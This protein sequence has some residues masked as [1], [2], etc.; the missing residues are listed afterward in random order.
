MLLAESSLGTKTAVVQSPETRYA[1]SGE[2][3][4]AYQVVG[5]APLD[6][7]YIPNG[8]HHV[9]LNWEN[10]PVARFLERLA[11]LT[12]L[13]VFDKRGTGMSDRVVGVPTLET[14]MDDVRA[15]MDAASSDRAVLFA[16][17]DAGPL[18]ALFAATFPERSAGLVL[19]NSTPRFV[20]GPDFPWLPSR[21]EAEGRVEENLRRAVD[22]ARRSELF[23]QGNPDA[24]E[25]EIR[26]FTRVFRISVSPGARAEAQRWNLDVDVS[27]IL[28][29]IRVPTL[30]L[31]RPEIP[32]PDVGSGRYFA[33]HIPGARLVELPGRNFGPP[34]G[35]TG[36]LFTEL[37]RFLD[38]AQSRRERHES[39]PERVLTTVLF[40][41]IV[42][43]TVRASELGDRA[44]GEL[45]G[46]HHSLIRGQLGHFRGQEMDT[47]GDGFFATFDGP[48]RAIR[49][50]CAIRDAV[51]DLGLQ[52]RAG[53]HTGECELIDDKITG[54]AVHTGARVA[55]AA[56]AG[57]VLVSGTVK[58]LVAGSG[59][60]FEDRG[61]H[62][63][64]GVPGEWRLYQVAALTS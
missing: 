45:L 7:V 8:A 20:R 5:E 54:I 3:H 57:E 61:E 16:I 43:A 48:A 18:C 56:N 12:R 22:P 44:W 46:K 60:E 25:E 15:V 1:K 26:S 50:A 2:V 59:I 4:I 17:G 28:P 29:S 35:D 53:L 52:M 40:T 58:D 47:A 49:C 64:K 19:V 9:E 62:A 51:R 24:T 42:D 21:G 38:Q 63:L 39:E 11:G 32:F 37:E 55:A 33:S 27:H 10:P 36:P 34:V 31:H 41:D 6:L 23:A 14:R 30:V 13:I